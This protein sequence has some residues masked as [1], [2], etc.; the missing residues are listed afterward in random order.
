[1]CTIFNSMSKE[2]IMTPGHKT[3]NE[4]NIGIITKIKRPIGEHHHIYKTSTLLIQ[5]YIYFLERDVY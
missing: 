4:I 1:M 5:I 2:T 3:H